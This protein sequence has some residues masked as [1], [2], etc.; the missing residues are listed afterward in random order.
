[1]KKNNKYLKI[2]KRTG[3]FAHQAFAITIGLVLLF[4]ILYAISVSFMKPEQILRVPPSFF[5][6]EV[7]LENYKEVLRISPIFRYMLNSFI[8]AVSASIARIVMAS[9]AAFAFSFF[10]FRGKKILFMLCLGTIMIP[11]DVVLVTNYRTVSS[12][13]LVNT[14]LGMMI[15]FMVN[16]MNIFML[17]QNFLTFSLSLREAAYIDGCGNFRFFCR[18]LVPTSMPTLATVFISSFISIWNTYLWPM[19]VTSKAE[20][21]T[22]QVGITRLNSADGMVFGPIMAGAVLVMI[23]TIAIFLIFRKKIV[24]GIMGGSVKG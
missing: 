23:P 12:M 10:R 19:V 21:Q 2:K 15:I 6:Q 13:G 8:I 16:A 14:Y 20:M 5:P 3:I 22:V 9:M 11:G 1:M 17:R 24:S 18:I 4:P 7:T